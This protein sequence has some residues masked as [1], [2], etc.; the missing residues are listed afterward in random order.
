MCS[1]EWDCP[2]LCFCLNENASVVTI[3]LFSLPYKLSLFCI[4]LHKH[5]QRSVMP[6]SGI[7]VNC[8]IMSNIPTS[9]TPPQNSS[10]FLIMRKSI[11]Y[12]ITELYN[13]YIYCIHLI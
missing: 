13:N 11:A 1:D 7:N 12:D 5:D 2:T 6:N 9:A 8:V 4:S 10:F 3:Y